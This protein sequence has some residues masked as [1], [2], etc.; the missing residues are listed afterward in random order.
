MRWAVRTG[1]VLAVG[2]MVTALGCG[3]GDGPELG[4]VTGTVTLDGKPLEGVII[5]FQPESGR[6]GTGETDSEGRYKLIYRYGVD[7]TKV[8][9]SKVS[10][11]WP[12]GVEGKP[13]IPEKY[14]GKTELTADVKSG[15]NTFD[16]DL[17]SK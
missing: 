4:E 14:A 10:F 9:P 3:R 17:K 6:A 12:M 2:L 13:G 11:A 5:N 15:S 7:G 1:L 16:F 8:G